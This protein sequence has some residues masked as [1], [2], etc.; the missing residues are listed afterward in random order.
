MIIQRELGSDTASFKDALDAAMRQDPDVIMLGEVRER[1]T[2]E[3][4]LKAA[5]TGH[6]VIS[7]IH[8]P[9]AVATVQR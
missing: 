1:E 7:A 5:R 8:T 4:C 3:T 6:L 9:D 2:A